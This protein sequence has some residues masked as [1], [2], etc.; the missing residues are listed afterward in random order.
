MATLR[1]DDIAADLGDAALL[2]KSPVVARRSAA[3]S[4]RIGLPRRQAHDAVVPGRCE[5]MVLNRALAML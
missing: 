3:A 5:A 1:P 4:S 2:P